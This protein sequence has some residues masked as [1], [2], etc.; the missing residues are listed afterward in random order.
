MLIT[1]LLAFTVASM[2]SLAAY[3]QQMYDRTGSP[4]GRY[5]H[6]RIYNRYGSYE[7]RVDSN[8]FYDRA[9]SYLGCTRD[10]KFYDR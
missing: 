6:G 9:G 2:I 8:R 10:D 4:I 3:S 5:D 7:G 1:R